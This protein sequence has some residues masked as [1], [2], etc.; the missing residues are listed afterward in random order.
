ME[1]N[2]ET[3]LMCVGTDD[4]NKIS[5]QNLKSV[6][7]TIP[8]GT[9]ILIVNTS[10]ISYDTYTRTFSSE[11][12][13]T[14]WN[15]VN[16]DS[17]GIAL[18]RDVLSTFEPDSLKIGEISIRIPSEGDT[19]ARLIDE[20]R[21]HDNDNLPKISTKLYNIL[22][23]T[24]EVDQNREDSYKTDTQALLALD[25]LKNKKTLVTHSH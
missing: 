15:E 6:P 9:A 25:L 24:E 19:R 1:M 11:R 20:L 23:V 3:A 4:Y 2:V 18:V 8:E 5:I 7:V 21:G 17:K 16:T 22:P 13:E 10:R 14:L 12:Q